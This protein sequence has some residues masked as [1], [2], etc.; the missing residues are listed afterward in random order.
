MAS[1]RLLTYAKDRAP[2]AGLLVDDKVVDLDSALRAHAR[3]TGKTLGFSGASVR[4]VIDNWAKARP[5]LSAIARDG[6]GRG[7]PM[8]RTRLLAPIA[9]VGTIWCAGANYYD[10]A[11]EMGTSV[12]KK[13]VEPFFFIKAGGATVIGPG[14]TARIPKWSK[15]IDWEAEIAVVIGRAGRNIKKAAAMKH[16]AGYTILNDLSARDTLIREDWPFRHDWMRGKTFDTAAPMGPWITPAS[17]IKDP[18]NL[19]IDLWVNDRHEQ[20]THSKHMVFD[21]AE[22]IVALS[23]Q[24]SLRPGDI[25]ST[26]TGAGVGRPKGRFL[27]PGDRVRIEVEGLGTLLLATDANIEVL[28]GMNGAWIDK[29]HDRRPPK[30]IILDMDSSVSPTHG[31]QEGTAYNGHFGCTCYHPL[32]LFN[33]FGDLEWCSLRPGNVHSADGWREVLEPVVERYRERNLR[34][35]FRGDAAFAAPDIYEF[36]ESEGFLYAIRLPKNQI[37]QES[38]AHLLTR[39]VGRPPNHVRRYYASFRY[40]AGSWD[41]KRRVVAKVEWHPGE[42]C[43]RV[44]FIV[45]NLSRPAERVVAFYNH[46]GTAEQY[47]K[48]GKYAIKWTRLSCSKFRNNEV[49]LQF[50]ALAY[51]LGN[52]M[53]TLALPKEVEHWSLTT[54][55]EKLVKIGAKVVRH[56]R[57]VTFQLAEVAVSKILFQKILAL[58]DDLRRSPVPA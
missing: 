49:R 40:Q 44:G 17:E 34:R 41:R 2:R 20:D 50:H 21:V 1:F 48:E 3:K 12:D 43:P 57:Y 36:L 53:R 38:I 6:S 54:L 11:A 29:V 24:I 58:I 15:Q 4:S 13:K 35:Y 26:G 18:Q 28:A 19:K 55:R 16:V 56:G 39:P 9:D 32:F 37:L 51:N 10:H 47:I 46:R 45:T 30:M 33:Q 5:M 52:F 31:E 23:R 8:A 14:A 22:Q 27:K 25:V 7:Q 42:L